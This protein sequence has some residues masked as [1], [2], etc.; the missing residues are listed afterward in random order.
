[1]SIIKKIFSFIKNIFSK[2][3]VLALEAPKEIISETKKIDFIESLKVTTVKEITKK[4]IETL[5][6]EGD[7][8]GIQ[9]GISA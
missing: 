7:G 1:M 4:K 3:K 8:L 9:K 6:C 2:N 5:I